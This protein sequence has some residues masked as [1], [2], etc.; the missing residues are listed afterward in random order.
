LEAKTWKEYDKISEKAAKRASKGSHDVQQLAEAIRSDKNVQVLRLLLRASQVVANIM[1]LPEQMHWG[2][3]LNL[4]VQDEATVSGL[5]VEVV[6]EYDGRAKQLEGT[7]NLRIENALGHCYE[8]M[9]EEQRALSWKKRWNGLLRRSTNEK[10]SIIRNV[11]TSA[12]KDVSFILLF[13]FILLTVVRMLPLVKDLH[14]N[15]TWSIA[16]P[17]TRRIL[18]THFRGAGRDIKRAGT[19]AFLVLCICLLGVGL[20][21]FLAD[22]PRN[23]R[24]LEE[25]TYCAERH[26][27]RTLKYICEVLTLFVAWKTYKLT[28]TASLY[29]VLTPAAC[30]T[31]ALPKFMASVPVRFCVGFACWAS[32]VFG[33]VW[34]YVQVKDDNTEESDVRSMFVVLF[35]CII[36]L[37][38][39]CTTS[40]GMRRAYCSA[41]SDSSTGFLTPSWSHILCLFLGPIEAIQLASVV[42]Y[43]Y[44]YGSGTFEAGDG[45]SFTFPVV[46]LFDRGLENEYGFSVAMGLAAVSVFLWVVVV[47]LPLMYDDDSSQMSKIRSLQRTPAFDFLYVMLSRIVY[48]SIVATLMRPYS[49]V[50][51]FG[52]GHDLA[53]STDAGIVCGGGDADRNAWST[54]YSS[55]ILLVFFLITSTILHSDAP[56]LL[57]AEN[58]SYPIGSDASAATVRFAPIYAMVIRLGQL[59]VCYLC[60]GFAS[61]GDRL[62]HLIAVI[63][64]SGLLALWCLLYRGHGCSLPLVGPIRAAGFFIVSW[65]G[66]AC[67]LREKDISVMG[68]GGLLVIA[69]IILALGI[70]AGIVI[71]N[72]AVE[73]WK[74]Q[75]LQA[76]LGDAVLSITQFSDMLIEEEAVGGSYEGVKSRAQQFALEV[77]GALTAPHLAR[78]LVRFEER[79]LSERLSYEFLISRESWQHELLRNDRPV[80]FDSVQTSL[81]VLKTAIKPRA[82]LATINKHILA[83]IFNRK[84]PEFVAWEV[85]SFMYD[86]THMRKMLSSALSL[87]EHGAP[88]VDTVHS[89]YYYGSAVW[90]YE[91]HSMAMMRSAR[92]NFGNVRIQLEKNQRAVQ[93]TETYLTRLEQNRD[94][95][96]ERSSF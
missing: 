92:G 42:L 1:T 70:V 22:I 13:C 90:D 62:P 10:R 73:S 58:S 12:A 33:S 17:K 18:V 14:A 56:D 39:L 47:T 19:F 37:I 83:L 96:Q 21:S 48:V 52:G 11:V 55:T 8:N 75:L 5:M 24:N 36:G 4:R 66:I 82:P 86:A 20:P 68:Y 93:Q 94:N 85:F 44:W 69:G 88:P 59:C 2:T 38:A 76:G 74:L 53:V 77:E 35:G 41:L 28:V 23:F 31:E 60:L 79:I 50:E 30:I 40:L 54:G 67:Y 49:C 51:N 15:Q 87:N 29:A 84:L 81:T 80:T 78:L 25:A 57:E 6:N 64:I 34:M 3:L 26:L 61:Q 71:Q 27:K 65:V 91:L 7:M 72:R 45:G 16:Q 95:Y 63:V 9:L 89:G 32:A 43:F 46:F